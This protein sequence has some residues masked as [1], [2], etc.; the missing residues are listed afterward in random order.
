MALGWVS[1]Y[2]VHN[3]GKTLGST[4]SNSPLPYPEKSPQNLS[5]PFNYLDVECNSV[6]PI[7]GRQKS[8]GGFHAPGQLQL[9]RAIPLQN[10]FNLMY[11]YHLYKLY[12]LTHLS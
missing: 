4:L 6:I 3:Q 11:D 7:L 12:A 1:L 8:E 5:I 10:F 9:C 2:K